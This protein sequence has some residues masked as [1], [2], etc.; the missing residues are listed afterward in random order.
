MP[1]DS[2]S[3]P[4]VFSIPR[5]DG[6][7]E[8]PIESGATITFC[9]ANGSGKTRL[10]VHIETQLGLLAHRVSAHRA[11][12]L[13]PSVPKISEKQA[14]SGLRTGETK[15]H[16]RANAVQYRRGRRWRSREAT[17]LLND[18]DYLLQAL[19]ADQSNRALKSHKILRTGSGATAEPT[20][21]EQL[22]EIWEMLLPHRKL[23]ITGDDI[24]VRLPG[25]EATY[26]ASEMSDGERAIFY[27]LGQTLVADEGSALI[28]DEPELHLHPS[29]MT[30]LWDKLVAARPDCTFVFITHNLEF[31]A[32]RP[33]S[34]YIVREYE[35]GD[36]WTID[37]VPAETGFSEEFTT[38]I[39][40]SRRPVLFVEG[41]AS[42]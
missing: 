28:V 29:I 23:V 16:S 12:S 25:I 1:N 13:N 40:G 5:K 36:L 20:K 7:R 35:L 32:G 3:L 14:L 30:L 11:L 27:L 39:L 38:L 24:A 31:A 19:F 2:T 6:F 41:A 37:P 10:A 33:G 17:S 22:S 18:F 21:F 42:P 9:G 15:S 4:S 26:P 8:F 34:K